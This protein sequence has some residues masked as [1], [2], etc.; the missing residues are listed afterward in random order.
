MSS[1]I[2][3]YFTRLSLP[4]PPADLA[5]APFDEVIAF[6][7]TM[8]RAHAAAIPF[9]NLNV[10][11]GERIDISPDAVFRKLVDDRRG[12]Y[13]HE[14]ARLLQLVLTELGFT[15][16]PHL[17]RILLRP[18]AS[19]P[20]PLSHQLTTVNVQG[21]TVVLDPGFGG[22]TPT[23]ALPIGVDR[24]SFRVI[25]GNFPGDT[26]FA[27]QSRTEDGQFRSL[28]GFN[29]GGPALQLSDIDTANWLTCTKPGTMFTANLVLARHFPDGTR[30][31]L[32]N[33]TINRNGERE[34]IPDFDTFTALVR[35]DFGVQ[36]TDQLLTTCWERLHAQPNS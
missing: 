11:A 1:N 2:E 34:D 12:G 35:E 18:D 33:T 9:E 8:L 30:I 28:Y 29:M 4:T 20:G 16:T 24:G 6:F 22:G 3:R 31:T 32:Q 27:V 10:Y 21:H 36:A 14:H 26:H 5:T 17:A 13:C 7:D 23:L 19:Q 15:P 25:H